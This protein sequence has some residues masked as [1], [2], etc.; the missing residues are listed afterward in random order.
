VRPKKVLIVLFTISLFL[1]KYI[2]SN[3][4]LRAIKA[5]E[6]NN[7]GHV[8]RILKKDNSII[9]KF[10]ITENKSGSKI[11]TLLSVAVEKGS[12]QMVELLLQHNADPNMQC[13]MYEY[14][15]FSAVRSGCREDDDEIVELLLEYGACP[16]IVSKGGN[17]AAGYAANFACSKVLETL[18]E[19]GADPSLKNKFGKEARVIFCFNDEDYL[20]TVDLLEVAMENQKRVEELLQSPVIEIETLENF[21]MSDA[22][23]LCAKIKILECLIDLHEEFP[24]DVS[25]D[26]IKKYFRR[27]PFSHSFLE[28]EKLLEFISRYQSITIK[29]VIFEMTD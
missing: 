23:P 20:E 25:A 18:F 3:E 9:D 22:V 7:L 8:E 10:F 27:I 16:N 21:V 12:A 24:D 6:E 2:F 29:N 5:I 1:S 13:K 15:L 26:N 17:T 14:P 4:L 28:N 19:Y 11:E